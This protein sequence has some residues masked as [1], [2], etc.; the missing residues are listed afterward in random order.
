MVFCI[1]KFYLKRTEIKQ[2]LILEAFRF[3]VV[4]SCYINAPF[5]DI[6]LSI[7]LQLN[8]NPVKMF[9][10]P[11]VYL[12]F[13]IFIVVIWESRSKFKRSI[14]SKLFV[15]KLFL[16]TQTVKSGCL[17]CNLLFVPIQ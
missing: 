12:Y 16:V 11:D 7:I 9:C 14:D 3:Q 15:D 5:Y 17:I 10:I 4:R 6:K 8:V 13:S 1:S 2:I